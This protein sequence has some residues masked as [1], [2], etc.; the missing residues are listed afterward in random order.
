[1]NKIGLLFKISESVIF[2]I[3]RFF[4]LFVCLVYVFNMQVWLNFSSNDRHAMNKRDYE[5]VHFHSG[6]KKKKKRPVRKVS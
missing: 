3:C 1:M 6:K 5:S 2:I 4:L